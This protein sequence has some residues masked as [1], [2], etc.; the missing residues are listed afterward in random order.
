MVIKEKEATITIYTDYVF[1]RSGEFTGL[2]QYNLSQEI[3]LDDYDKHGPF[4]AQASYSYAG[5]AK[6]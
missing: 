2:S 5:E 1:L 4:V 6:P 3:F